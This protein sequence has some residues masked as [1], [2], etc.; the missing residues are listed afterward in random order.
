M[1][2]TQ[3]KQEPQQ[4]R[5]VQQK[6]SELFRVKARETTMANVLEPRHPLSPAV[7]SRYIWDETRVLYMR[8]FENHPSYRA[9]CVRGHMGVGKTAMVTQ[10]HA[11]LGR[12]MLSV[13][14]D[15][16][17]DRTALF[18]HDVLNSTG[19]ME[20]RPGPV[21]EAA[22]KGYALLINEYNM[23]PPDVTACL[24][25]FLLGE[26]QYI[27]E[28]KEVIKP[29]PAFR[30]YATI[31]PDGGEG[32]YFGRK[33]QDAANDERFMFVDLGEP[34]AEVETA[35]VRAT[36]QGRIPDTILDHTV[37]VLT[38]VAKE[39][40]RLFVGNNDGGD[41]IEVTMSPRTLI[42]WAE[43]I[44]MLAGIEAK[45]INSVHYALEFVLTNRPIEA[46]T[47]QAIHKIL[48]DKLGQPRDLAPATA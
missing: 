31:N 17:T 3:I 26:A 37:T 4:P 44:P 34:P 15:K 7:N 48:Q 9:M 21:L 22:M 10:Y 28:L 23:A 13:T 30:V 16:D 24:N 47:K 20:F 5:F 2:D 33:L 12:P 32:V 8:V 43:T 1:Q 46:R 40:R 36:L 29:H 41:A 35:V 18:G 42:R 11:I 14:L 39:I 25:E 45:G 27:P 38:S 19:G 6:V